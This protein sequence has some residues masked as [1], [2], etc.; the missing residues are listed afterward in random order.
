LTDYVD[1]KIEIKF[2]CEYPIKIMGRNVDDFEKVILSVLD[3]CYADFSRKTI[4][5]RV[6]KEEKFISLT[7]T[8][9]ATGKLQLEELHKALKATGL[10]SI[11]L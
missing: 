9:I 10:V 3:K 1:Q 7:V 11:V 6:S 8:I 4:T 2:P 5:R